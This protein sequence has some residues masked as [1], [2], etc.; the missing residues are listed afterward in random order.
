MPQCLFCNHYTQGSFERQRPSRCPRCRQYTMLVPLPFSDVIVTDSPL[1]QPDGFGGPTT[2]ILQSFAAH[3]FGVSL[4]QLLSQPLDY[5]CLPQHNETLVTIWQPEVKLTSKQT[6]ALL[7]VS[8]DWVG[9]L[10]TKGHFPHAQRAAPSK[11]NYRRGQWQIPL[12]DVYAVLNVDKLGLRSDVSEAS[13]TSLRAKI[14]QLTEL[15]LDIGERLGHDAI[16]GIDPLPLLDKVIIAR[17]KLRLQ[18]PGS[19]SESLPT[20]LRLPRF[21]CPRRAY[22]Y[23]LSDETGR[24]MAMLLSPELLDRPD[25]AVAYLLAA[26]KARGHTYTLWVLE[27]D[28]VAAKY[29]F[30]PAKE[31]EV[32]L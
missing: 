4:D 6:A 10:A 19:Q 9:R 14:D 16:F 12:G 24:P 5:D 8:V 13:P 31:E 32:G 28:R 27:N 3:A 22:L 25:D 20:D 15:S 30:G 26:I 23:D 11:P 18:E 7:G 2:A 29:E 1:A 17:A 21:S